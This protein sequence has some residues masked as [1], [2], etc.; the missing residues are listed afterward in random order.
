MSVTS[1]EHAMSDGTNRPPT[2]YYNGR[3]I[4]AEDEQPTQDA[5]SQKHEQIIAAI[6]ASLGEH[7]AALYAEAIQSSVETGCYDATW[8]DPG[9]VMSYVEVIRKDWLSK[10]E[11]SSALLIRIQFLRAFGTEEQKK[12]LHELLQ[13]PE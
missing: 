6:K 11:D 2:R 10:Q 13:L 9:R 5:I 3:I 12:Q 1:T 7:L 4:A 8:P